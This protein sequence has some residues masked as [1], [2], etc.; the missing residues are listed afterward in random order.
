MG[1][2]SGFKKGLDFV[3][4]IRPKQWISWDLFKASSLNTYNILKDV[5][6]VPTASKIESFN[7]AVIRHQLNEL[8]IETIKNR[9][10]FFSMFFLMCSIG[11]FIYALEGFLHQQIMKGIVASCLVL[12]LAA[13]SFRYHF[14]YFQICKKKLGCTLTDWV[15]FVKS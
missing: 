13:Q 4:Y 6:R 11:I 10:Y 14:W 7:Q 1:F 2:W 9:F 3:F 5:Y 15:N 12:F 8:Q